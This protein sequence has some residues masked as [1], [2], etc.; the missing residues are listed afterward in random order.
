MT[1]FIVRRLVAA[2]FIVLAASFIVYMLM[3]NAGDPLAFTAEIQNPT[4]RAGGRST[5][6][7]RR[8][9]STSTRSPGTSCGSATCSQGDFGISAR[10]QQPVIDDL[11][12][13]C[14]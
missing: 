13:G 4:Q 8:S 9:T 3:A 11:T 1:T 5:P 2:F 14:R 6:S 10:T 7:P 12:A